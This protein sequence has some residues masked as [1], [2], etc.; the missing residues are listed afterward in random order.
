MEKTR[1]NLKNMSVIVLGLTVL[2]LI[3]II[4]ELFFGELN[5]ELNGAEIPE[6]V[7]SNIVLIAQV[8]I[9]VVS[10]LLLLP[11]FYIG[12]KGLKVA[13]SPDSSGGHIVWGII[14]LVFAVIGLF[15]PLLGLIQGNG[16]PLGNASELLSI[17]VDAFV[18][19]EYV[20][21]ARAVR[22]AA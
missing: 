3:D 8:F 13:K 2:S 19:F 1:R 6:G 18:L 21:F 22:D 9:L 16:N 4:F 7:G 10:F 15:S 12:I 11:Q 20:R 17:A 14:L 5:R